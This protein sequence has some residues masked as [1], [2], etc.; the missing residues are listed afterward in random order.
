MRAQMLPQAVDVTPGRAIGWPDPSWTRSGCIVSASPIAR[1]SGHPS[2]VNA[3]AKEPPASLV[4]FAA[5]FLRHDDASKSIGEFA[6]C[7][8]GT[9]RLECVV[10]AAGV[11]PASEAEFPETSTS[12]SRIL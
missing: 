5:P 10:E 11:E 7:S 6:F 3:T 8:V 9:C 1:R 12:I 2:V 4:L